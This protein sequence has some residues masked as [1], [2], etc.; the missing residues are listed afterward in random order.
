MSSEFVARFSVFCAG[1]FTAYARLLDAEGF[2]LS[3]AD[4]RVSASCGSIA[5]D[6]FKSSIR[7]FNVTSYSA[8]AVAKD[9]NPSIHHFRVI[10]FAWRH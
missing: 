10:A 4:F 7:R 9:P 5:A 3:M 6:G 8:L 1:Q 2:K